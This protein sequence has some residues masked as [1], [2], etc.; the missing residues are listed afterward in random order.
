[1]E[2]IE[3]FLYPILAGFLGWAYSSYR[4]KDQKESDLLANIKKIISLQ[5]DHISKAEKSLA[6]SESICTRL[7]AKL[8]R[9]NKSIR[10]ANSCPHTNEGDGCPVLAQEELNE[11][12]YELDCSNCELHKSKYEQ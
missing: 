2:I 4:N 10:K 7:E 5:D 12:I 3:K 6:R 1:M 8:D 11:H 9:K